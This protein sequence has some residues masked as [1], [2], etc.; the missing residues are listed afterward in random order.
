MQKLRSI[1]KRQGESARGDAAQ[2]ANPAGGQEE[3]DTPE[4]EEPMEMLEAGEAL[5]RELQDEAECG[6]GVFE[7]CPK[8]MELQTQ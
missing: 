8:D 4:G 1:A 7:T 5:V 3:S 2:V 6:E